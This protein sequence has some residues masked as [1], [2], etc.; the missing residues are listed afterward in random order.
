MHLKSSSAP[1]LSLC[2]PVVSQNEGWDF[3]DRQPWLYLN[4][5]III[6]TVNFIWVKIYI[7]YLFMYLKVLNSKIKKRVYLFLNAESI[8]YVNK[9]CKS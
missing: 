8:L 5:S 1:V 3:V 9:L 2:S 6:K 4:K 7:K